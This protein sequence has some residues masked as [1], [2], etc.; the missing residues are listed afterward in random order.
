M[1]TTSWPRL[2]L[3]VGQLGVQG[4]AHLAAAGEHVDGA[5]VVGAEEGAVGRRRLGELVDLLAQGGDVLAGLAEGVGELLVLGDGL[6]QLALGLEQ[7]LLEGADPL[8]G[9]LQPAPQGDDLFLERLGLLLQLGRLALV[10]GQPQ[11][12]LVG[13]GQRDHLLSRGG[14]HTPSIGPTGGHSRCFP[15]DGRGN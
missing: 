13:V 6:L 10:G 12:V 3:V 2:R 11:S 8:G 15:G 5:V 7:L 1:R 4:D 9:V 14:D